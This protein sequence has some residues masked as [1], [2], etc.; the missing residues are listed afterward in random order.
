MTQR[1]VAGSSPA[2]GTP[3]SNTI[4]ENVMV[5]AWYI[6]SILTA[7]LLLVDTFTTYLSGYSF[8][9]G[10]WFAFMAVF[11]FAMIFIDREQ[12]TRI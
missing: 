1:K 4:W 11:T 8:A 9:V 2:F 5:I 12:G 7:I 6:C 3:I 10:V